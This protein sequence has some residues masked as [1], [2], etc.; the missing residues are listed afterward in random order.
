MEGCPIL[1]SGHLPAHSGEVICWSGD[2]KEWGH[3]LKEFRQVCVVFALLVANRGVGFG[4]DG[5][6][7]LGVVPLPQHGEER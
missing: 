5:P 6:F 1:A 3:E 2:F 7:G 4:N